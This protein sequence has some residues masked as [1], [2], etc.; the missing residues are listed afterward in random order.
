MPLAK[1]AHEADFRALEFRRGQRQLHA[2]GFGR[3]LGHDAPAQVRPHVGREGVREL[4]AVRPVQGVVELGKLPVHR[5][6]RAHGGLHG[7]E[8]VGA[9]D[10]GADAQRRLPE[11]CPLGMD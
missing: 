10:V 4:A 9:L 7:L 5:A 2:G 1:Q 8:D 3:L 11:A 6:V